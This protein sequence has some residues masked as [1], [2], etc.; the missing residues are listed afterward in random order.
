MLALAALAPHPLISIPEIGKKETA[1]V[2]KTAHAL[3]LLGQ[4]LY[5][6]KPDI[7]VILTPHAPLV[8]HA[9]TIN[10]SPVVRIDLARYGNLID[11]HEFKTDI[12]FG[13]RIKESVEHT[14]PLVLTADPILDYGSAVCL[15]HLVQGTTTN[16]LR[17]VILGTPKEPGEYLALGKTISGHINQTTQRV[18]VIATGDLLPGAARNAL[19]PYRREAASYNQ[20]LYQYMQESDTHNIISFATTQKESHAPCLAVP[21]LL[22]L[23][24]LGE[25]R[26][27]LTPLSHETA[28]GVGYVT[29]LAQMT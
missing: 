1:R 4:E 10:Q 29:A 3:R 25:R 28:L 27:A 18:A 14:L 5:A 22:L 13:Y 6:A 15:W 21:L 24:I 7:L 26:Y 16:E 17:V 12:G 9:Y 8:E 19:T 2:R 11:A 20:K 23:S